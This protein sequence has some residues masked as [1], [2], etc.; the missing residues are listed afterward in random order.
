MQGQ[1]LS[2]G[3]AQPKGRENWGRALCLKT[4]GQ[5]FGGQGKF[6]YD[7]VCILSVLWFHPNFQNFCK[8][9]GSCDGE[10]GGA[11]REREKERKS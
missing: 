11:E 4:K 2:Q 10:R 6:E 9:L 8:D 7:W 5:G 3:Y 1:K